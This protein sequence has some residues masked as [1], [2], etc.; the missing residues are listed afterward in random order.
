MVCSVLFQQRAL[1]TVHYANTMQSRNPSFVITPSVLVNI[2]NLY[3][4]IYV[5]IKYAI[6]YCNNFI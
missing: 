5:A 3:F 6:L 4:T 2:V 1:Y